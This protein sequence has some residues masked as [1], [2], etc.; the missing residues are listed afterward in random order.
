MFIRSINPFGKHLAQSRCIFEWPVVKRN[1]SDD[2]LK[3]L[4]VDLKGTFD[5][6]TEDRVRMT[7]P[8][9]QIDAFGGLY[10]MREPFINGHAR[11]A[12]HA[13]REGRYGDY[14]LVS[15]SF[16]CS[17][18]NHSNGLQTVTQAFLGRLIRAFSWSSDLLSVVVAMDDLNLI[19]DSNFAGNSLSIVQA[20]AQRFKQVCANDA[21]TWRNFLRSRA[22]RAMEVHGNVA[23]A[24][25]LLVLSSLGDLSRYSWC[26]PLDKT[27]V[28]MFPTPNHP[29]SAN[30]VLWSYRD[31]QVLSLAA[32]PDHVAYKDFSKMEAIWRGIFDAQ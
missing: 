26:P 1:L 12:G 21:D 2:W 22:A 18:K 8:H 23:T 11:G 29:A 24:P 25:P 28:H 9:A 15:S 5:Y 32:S 14:A 3:R 6:V 10:F 4:T 16:S 31:L 27:D 30:L 17:Y 19:D 13:P 20:Q 7:V